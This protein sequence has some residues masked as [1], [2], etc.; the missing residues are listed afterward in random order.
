MG[1]FFV[2]FIMN[3]VNTLNKVKDYLNKSNF[4]AADLAVN[5][6][7]RKHP[8]NFHA[9]AYKC[10]ISINISSKEIVFQNFEKALKSN[11]DHQLASN[12]VQYLIEKEHLDIA[13]KINNKILLQNNENLIAQFNHARLLAKQQKYEAAFKIFDDLINK[14]TQ[15]VNIFISYGYNL[16]Y[17][18][19]YE[20]AINVY[21]AGLNHHPSN[22]NLLFNLGITL[23]NKQ[24]FNEAEKYLKLALSIYSRNENLILTLVSTYVKNNKFIEARA[25]LHE[26]Q[27]INPNNSIA[28]FQLGAVE[29]NDGNYHKAIE[30]FKYSIS[31]NQNDVECH[32]HLGLTYLKMFDYV[33]VDVE[34]RYRI[35]REGE[36]KYGLFNDFDVSDLDDQD[37]LLICKEQGIGDEILLVRLLPF[38]LKKV[39]NITYI[40]DDRLKNILER[41]LPKI[42]IIPSSKYMEEGKDNY[43]K[44]KKINLGTIFRYLNPEDF[45]SLIDFWKAD[46]QKTKFLQRLSDKKLK[47]GISWK[48]KNDS[49]GKH[50]SLDLKS[51]YDSLNINENKQLIN[52]QYGNINDDLN[53]LK[54]NKK[55]IFVAEL[56]YFNDIDGLFSL[57]NVC[58]LII[59]TSNVTAHIAGALGKKTFLLVP[60]K[61]GKIWYWN[62][63][64]NKNPWYKSIKFIEQ[65]TDKDWESALKKLSELDI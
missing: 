56:D 53:S 58:D 42:K 49:I 13:L 17:L 44:Y 33:N 23:N 1:F 39:K 41:N 9:L 16:N 64:I 19:K 62:S 30:L 12:Y 59:T 22:F 3:L 14:F 32:F 34:Y 60:K 5:K 29:M 51:L 46:D 6:I 31:K 8:N 35:K 11:F 47:I 24:D 40:C 2:K 20:E 54:Q 18:K 38:L 26:L 63:Y 27:K 48:S 10:I 21:K 50:K 37:E 45:L 7:L 15:N 28:P 65:E 25:L 61:N 57:V 43:K 4:S 55:N 52:L 36:K